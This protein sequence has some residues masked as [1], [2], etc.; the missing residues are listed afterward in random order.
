MTITRTYCDRCRKE[1]IHPT[2]RKLC[3]SDID[4]T[5]VYDLCDSCYD[6]LYDW[7]HNPNMS[8]SFSISEIVD[9]LVEYGQHDTK[10]HLG[11]TIKYSPSEI[12]DILEGGKR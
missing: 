8:D 6:K 3:L 10:F 11:E 9:I 4:R 2:K 5:C 7:C 1:I 12:R